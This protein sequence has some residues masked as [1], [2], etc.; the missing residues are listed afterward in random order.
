MT[1]RF[2]DN[3]LA[4]MRL[5]WLD[6]CKTRRI[7]VVGSEKMVIYDDVE[8]QEKIKVYDKRVD[9]IR[10]TDTFGEFQFAY[11]YGD[12]IS[13]F[14]RFDEPLRV[15][16]NHFLDCIR[17]GKRTPVRRLQR[18]ASGSDRRGGSEVPANGQRSDFVHQWQYGEQGTSR[19]RSGVARLKDQPM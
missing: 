19:Y 13:P 1:L 16:C 15:E 4:H 5:S 8:S 18:P 9:A 7:T 12:V 6:P 3:V 17:R 11:H 14:V 2:P 10:H